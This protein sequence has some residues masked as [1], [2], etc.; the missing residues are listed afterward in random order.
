VSRRSRSTRVGVHS[1]ITAQASR[2]KPARVRSRALPEELTVSFDVRV[3]SEADYLAARA[4]LIAAGFVPCE[5]PG[6]ADYVRLVER[7]LRERG[8]V[9]QFAWP[10][11]AYVVSVSV[12]VTVEP[13]ATPEA[14]SDAA[15]AAANEKLEEALGPID[16]DPEIQWQIGRLLSI[17]TP[18]NQPE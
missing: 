8:E 17:G 10:A 13:R 14:E 6:R 1:S 2:D 18:T 7:K 16:H 4:R 15:F 9:M 12:D 5:W 3:F 11:D